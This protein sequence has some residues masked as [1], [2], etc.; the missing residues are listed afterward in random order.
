MDTLQTPLTFLTYFGFWK[1]TK[2]KTGLKSF[3]YNLFSFTFLVIFFTFVASELIQLFFTSTSKLEQLPD[4]L[5]LLLTFLNSCYKM[6]FLL[7]KKDEV[8]KL[9]KMLQKSCCVPK[10][11][12]ELDIQK[13]S[14][15]INR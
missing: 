12:I 10:N 11:E 4:T 14:D 2:W 6:V 5:H 15:N 8:V 7:L 9:K 3:M 13:R 1:P